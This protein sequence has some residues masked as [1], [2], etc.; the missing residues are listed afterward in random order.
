[1]RFVPNRK[2]AVFDRL[3][4]RSTFINAPHDIY[5]HSHAINGA[6]TCVFSRHRSVKS[7]G[8]MSSFTSYKCTNQAKHTVAQVQ[9]WVLHTRLGR[10]GAC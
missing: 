1:M 3:P 9:A 8:I 10:H 6:H 7:Y 2:S 4:Q 5:H